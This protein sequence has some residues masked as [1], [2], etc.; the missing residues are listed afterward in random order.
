MQKTDEVLAAI[1]QK[2]IE[3]AT[4][5]GEFLTGQLP[6]LAKQLL[7]FNGVTAIV[8]IL[9]A[10][11]GLVFTWRSYRWALALYKSD[12]DWSLTFLIPG[13]AGVVS[14]SIFMFNLHDFLK[15]ALAPKLYLLEYI[16]DIL[17]PR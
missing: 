8:W 10:S 7:L 13:I 1:L 17:N 3:A 9:L 6:D 15:I 2:S 12:D 16:A 4:A 14:V 11:V 5:G